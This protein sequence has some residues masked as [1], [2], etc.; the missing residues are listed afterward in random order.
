MEDSINLAT[1]GLKRYICT[2]AEFKN[3]IGF[4]FLFYNF[5]STLREVGHGYNYIGVEFLFLEC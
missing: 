2:F 3:V 4:F 1:L 5:S